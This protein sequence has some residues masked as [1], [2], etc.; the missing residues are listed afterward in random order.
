MEDGEVVR[1]V[2]CSREGKWGLRIGNAGLEKVRALKSVFGMLIVQ[3]SFSKGYRV[4]QDCDSDRG[5]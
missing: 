4:R 5:I 1:K 2:E 3:R